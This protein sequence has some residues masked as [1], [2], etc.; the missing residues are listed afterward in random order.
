M[1]R[2]EDTNYPV[3]MNESGLEIKFPFMHLPSL[4]LQE[5]SPIPSQHKKLFF[6]LTFNTAETL[7]MRFFFLA[8]HQLEAW[9]QH[10]MTARSSLDNIT[11]RWLFVGTQTESLMP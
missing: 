11:A 1:P 8:V 10:K 6:F 5:T 9:F 4:H 2:E 3:S 7:L